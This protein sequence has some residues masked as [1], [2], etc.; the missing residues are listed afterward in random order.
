[1]SF[2][3]LRIDNLAG[4]KERSVRNSSGDT[5]LLVAVEDYLHNVRRD[6]SPWDGFK[7]EHYFVRYEVMEGTGYSILNDG[8]MRIAK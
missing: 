1:M 5:R 3:I 4:N 6:G 8:K 2:N 7:L